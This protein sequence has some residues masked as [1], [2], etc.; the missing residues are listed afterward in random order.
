MHQPPLP[1]GLCLRG[2]TQPSYPTPDA[3]GMDTQPQALP[4]PLWTSGPK[5]SQTQGKSLQS[6]QKKNEKSRV[7]R[8]HEIK[9]E[10]NEG[11]GTGE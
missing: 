3:G 10:Y 4:I 2:G 11:K 9:E 8:R 5:T 1:G 7:G 6:G